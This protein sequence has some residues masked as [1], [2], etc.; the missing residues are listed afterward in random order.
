MSLSSSTGA[1]VTAT[2]SSSTTYSVLGTSGQ[3]SNVASVSIM[4]EDQPVADF[5]YTPDSA[6]CYNQP[7]YFDGALLSVNATSYS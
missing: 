2:P 1:S 4:V 7:I 5:T 6:L 3:C